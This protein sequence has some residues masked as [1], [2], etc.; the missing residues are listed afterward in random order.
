MTKTE[1]AV[2]HQKLVNNYNH[3]LN[4]IDIKISQGVPPSELQD[5]EQLRDRLVKRLAMLYEADEK[6]GFA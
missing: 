3:N 6:Y 1:Q 5:L 4:A 2:H